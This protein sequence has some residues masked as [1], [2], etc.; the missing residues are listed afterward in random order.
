MT[1]KTIT[2]TCICSL[3]AGALAGC[4]D[5]SAKGNA[6]LFVESE[7]TITDGLTP[8]TALDN[9]KDGWTVTYS[10]FVIGLGNAHAG[11]SADASATLTEPKIQ[12]INLQSLPT[13]GLVLAQWTGVAEGRWDKVGYDQAY[14]TASSVAAAGTAAA[15]VTAMAAAGASLWLAG[16]ITKGGK[17]VTFDWLLKSGV[18]WSD[19]GPETGDK[20][21]AVPA[22][23]TT[24]VKATIHGDHWFFNN[25]PEGAETTD[26][27]AEWVATVDTMTGADGKVSI[28]DLKAV[29][30][31]MVFPAGTYSLSNQLGE[32]ITNAHD[33]VVT[34]ARTIGHLQG[35]GECST[36]K[37]L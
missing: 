5:G 2:T 23:G 10:K 34:Q 33:F 6:T 36:L 12:V 15:D 21:F 20:G 17:T 1:L 29:P 27:Q 37:K 19:C 32:T 14:V 31:A 25:F 9:I 28:D 26:R 22:G 35:E 7:A 8:G 24:Q 13:S 16:S 4:G 30:A 3:F 18:A 11:K